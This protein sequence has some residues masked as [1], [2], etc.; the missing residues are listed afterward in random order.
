LW[1]R[2]SR[3]RI[4]SLTL[5]TKRLQ[6]VCFGAEAVRRWDSQRARRRYDKVEADVEDLEGSIYRDQHDGN[7]A[8]NL[9]IGHGG[10]DS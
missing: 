8:A 2:R 9:L 1:S 10:A 5:T 3:L 4:L 6:L 7:G